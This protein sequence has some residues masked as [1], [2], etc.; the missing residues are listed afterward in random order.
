[1]FN[2]LFFANVIIQNSQVLNRYSQISATRASLSSSP[3]QK[4]CLF[5]AS[6]Q[7]FTKK[8]LVS[9]INLALIKAI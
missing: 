6:N 7:T 8:K 9:P 1:M 3:W 5:T 2:S 4:H